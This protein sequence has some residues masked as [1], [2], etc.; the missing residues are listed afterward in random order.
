VLSR[1][2]RT[3][4]LAVCCLGF[5]LSGCSVK[6]SSTPEASI[7]KESLETGIADVLEQQVGQ[8]PD[9]ITCP[10][11]VKAAAGESIRCELASGSTKYGLSAT[12]NSFADG[13]ANYSVKVDDQPSN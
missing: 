13:K 10:G 3:V 8:R 6:V 7:T 2:V 1:P 4:V 9:S 5:T 12:V 11:P